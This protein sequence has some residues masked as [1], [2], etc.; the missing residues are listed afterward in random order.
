HCHILYH[1]MAGMGRIFS[2]QNSPK[3]PELPHPKKAYEKLKR[4][5]SMFYLSFQNDFATNGNDG[6]LSY[7]NTRWGL[8]AEWRLGYNDQSGY[9]VETHFGRY[10]GKKQWFFPYVGV[11]WRYRKGAAQEKSLFGQSNTHNKRAVLHIGLQYTLP[12]L[13]IA[14]AS[15]DHTGHL[16]LQLS[17]KDI[18]LSSRLR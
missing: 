7:E 4:E 5:N 11:D 14:D 16:R 15:V 2:Y 1:M 12:W 10:F 9:E 18:P 13:I 17:R 3:N 8:Q 6:S